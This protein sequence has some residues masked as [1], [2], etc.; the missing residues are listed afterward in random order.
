MLIFYN[1]YFFFLDF[2]TYDFT[3][4]ILMTRI[5]LFNSSVPVHSMDVIYLPFVK[6]ESIG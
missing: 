4:C 1:T 5:V 6:G 2:L 3:F